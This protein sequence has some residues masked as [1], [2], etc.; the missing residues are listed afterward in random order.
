MIRDRDKV[1]KKEIGNQPS[2]VHSF[3]ANCGLRGVAA[4]RRL[5]GTHS[6]PTLGR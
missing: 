5:P 2:G 3:T 6:S 4:R 1:Y